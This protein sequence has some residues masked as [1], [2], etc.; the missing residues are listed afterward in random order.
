[1][2]KLNAKSILSISIVNTNIL[3]PV[4]LE[5]FEIMISQSSA[6]SCYAAI[7]TPEIGARISAARGTGTIDLLRNN[8]EKGA[9]SGSK[10]KTPLKQSNFTYAGAGWPLERAVVRWSGRDLYVEIFGTRI[11]LTKQHSHFSKSGDVG[12]DQVYIPDHKVRKYV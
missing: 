10:N 1:M 9:L 5:G 3:C 6:S 7:N 4:E 11:F 12:I 2:H 8:C